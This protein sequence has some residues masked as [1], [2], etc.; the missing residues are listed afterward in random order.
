MCAVIMLRLFCAALLA[1]Q[2]RTTTEISCND[3]IVFHSSLDWFKDVFAT[4]RWEVLCFQ[5]ILSNKFIQSINLHHPWPAGPQTDTSTEELYCPLM[6][7]LRS[8]TDAFLC[9]IRRYDC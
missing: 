6:S 7:R 3:V 2:K 5:F 8:L 1:G 4:Q 9:G